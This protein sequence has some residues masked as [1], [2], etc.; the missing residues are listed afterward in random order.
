MY[1]ERWILSVVSA[2]CNAF[3]VWAFDAPAWGYVATL[4]ITYTTCRLSSHILS[5]IERVKGYTD[6]Y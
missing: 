5:A 3:I 6:D 1:K 2:F 4:L